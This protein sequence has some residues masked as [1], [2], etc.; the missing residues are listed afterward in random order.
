[1]K[2]QTFLTAIFLLGIHVSVIA[3]NVRLLL[4]EVIYAVPGV[5]MN[6]YYNN[7]ITVPNP[8]NYVFSVDCAKGRNMQMRI[9]RSTR[10]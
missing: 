9:V 3:E 7:I 10:R 1:M 8:A 4:P 5:E 6:V 2:I